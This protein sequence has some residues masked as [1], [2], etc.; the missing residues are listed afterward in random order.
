LLNNSLQS[1]SAKLAVTRHF[2]AL[3]L[4][5]QD[6]ARGTS[7]TTF[8][9]SAPPHLR[10]HASP[11]LITSGGSGPKALHASAQDCCITGN[12]VE[13]ACRP[14]CPRPQRPLAYR[15][16]LL[17]RL[18]PFTVFV[19]AFADIDSMPFT[20]CAYRSFSNSLPPGHHSEYPF[21]HFT[22]GY[23]WNTRIGAIDITPCN[24]ASRTKACIA[25]PISAYYARML[26]TRG[27][28]CRVCRHTG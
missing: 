7:T 4:F 8:V 26:H 11:L 13:K 9:A 22:Y 10:L 17:R 18:T 21:G 23:G 1:C 3:T 28:Y 25:P 12:V 6:A 14:L 15:R 2:R 16:D 19:V 24:P 20:H 5:S 27:E